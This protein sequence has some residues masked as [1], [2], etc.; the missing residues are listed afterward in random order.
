[1]SHYVTEL[2]FSFAPRLFLLPW[3]L[4]ATLIKSIINFLVRRAHTDIIKLE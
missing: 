3:Q 4:G 1:M 2:Q